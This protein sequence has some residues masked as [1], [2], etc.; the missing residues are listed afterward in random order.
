MISNNRSAR[1]ITLLQ[2]R[3]TADTTLSACHR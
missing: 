2:R 3:F 1:R